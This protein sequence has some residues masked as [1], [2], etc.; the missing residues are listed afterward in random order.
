M[1]WLGAIRYTSMSSTKVPSGVSSPE[2]CACPTCSADWRRCRRSRCDR[3]ERV[4]PGDLDLAHVAD[5][6]Q[7]GPRAHRHVLGGDARVLDRHVPAGERHHAGVG[8]AMARVQRGFAELGDGRVGHAGARNV[9]SDLPQLQRRRAARTADV[10]MRSGGNQECDG[11]FSGRLIHAAWSG[12]AAGRRYRRAA[13]PSPDRRERFRAPSAGA[14]R[15]ASGRGTRRRSRPD[16]GGGVRTRRRPRRGRASTR[17][18]RSASVSSRVSRPS[19]G[20]SSTISWSGWRL[21]TVRRP[22]SCFMPC[23]RA[24]IRRGSGSTASPLPRAPHA[25]A[26]HRGR[27]RRRAREVGD[28][29]ANHGITGSERRRFG[30]RRPPATGSPISIRSSVVF[31]AP[32][33]PST[34]SD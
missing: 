18:W 25:D 8:S 28:G 17:A 20:S 9:R 31:P 2:Y 30:R 4:L 32:F 5:V 27:Q 33:G 19:H 14:P 24:R 3:G 34:P 22:S 26:L 13:P 23:D 11:R 29:R 16:R 7:P 12:R 1:K 10:T 21:S 15:E 6:E